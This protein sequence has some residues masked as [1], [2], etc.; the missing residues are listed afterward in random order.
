MRLVKLDL[1]E[2][3]Y[4]W[5]RF[6]LPYLVRYLAVDNNGSLYGLLYDSSRSTSSTGGSVIRIGTIYLQDEKWMET[7]VC[8]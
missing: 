8:I 7:L 1:K 6:Q 2:A 5:I 4:Y 3:Y